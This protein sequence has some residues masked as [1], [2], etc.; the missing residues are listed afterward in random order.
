MKNRESQ[1]KHQEIQE[2]S[3]DG[4][5]E[6][7]PERDFVV[8]NLESKQQ[9]EVHREDQEHI[10]NLLKKLLT[11]NGASNKSEVKKESIFAD[12]LEEKTVQQAQQKVERVTRIATNVTDFIPIVGSAKMILEGVRGRQ[13]GTEQKIEGVGRIVHTVS[14]VVFLALDMTGVGAIASEFGK[15]VIKVGERT[16]V[17]TLEENLAKEIV[18]KEGGKLVARGET[19]I[20]TKEKIAKGV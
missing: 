12:T 1:P 3:P 6:V 8:H 14:G 18:Q 20:D 5:K 17:R 11:P 19:R 2:A 7:N 13:Y 15:G 10:Q 16:L 9:A 4:V